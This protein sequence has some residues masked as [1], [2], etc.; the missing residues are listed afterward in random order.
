MLDITIVTDPTTDTTNAVVDVN[1]KKRV[2]F[3]DPTEL[4]RGEK[5]EKSL[6]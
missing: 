4:H 5:K 1:H 2:T 6:L 3:A